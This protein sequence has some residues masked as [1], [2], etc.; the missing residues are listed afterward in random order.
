MSFLKT[1]FCMKKYIQGRWLL[2]FMSFSLKLTTNFI[3]KELNFTQVYTTHSFLSYYT[4]MYKKRNSYME[5]FSNSLWNLARSGGFSL[6]N[7]VGGFQ[8]T[9]SK[10][11]S[12]QGIWLF[13]LSVLSKKMAALRTVQF[14]LSSWAFVGC[15]YSGVWPWPLHAN[16][17]V[18]WCPSS[19]LN[20]DQGCCFC[21][22]NVI[23]QV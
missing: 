20:W 3:T 21:N 1:I 17:W 10:L 15:W 19:L 4:C 23:G 5:F 9:L 12:E 14:R 2:L 13:Q 6:L 22:I 11:L 18:A 16:S 8:P 7:G